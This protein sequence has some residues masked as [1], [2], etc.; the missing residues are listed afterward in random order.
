M[1][2][3]DFKTNEQAEYVDDERQQQSQRRAQRTQQRNPPQQN[4][5][6]KCGLDAFTR[7]GIDGSGGGG[8]S[9]SIALL[10]QI[11]ANVNI[12]TKKRKGIRCQ[13]LLRSHFLQDQL[14]SQRIRKQRYRQQQQQYPSK[15]LSF[16]GARNQSLIGLI[17]MLLI[18]GGVQVSN[19]NMCC[20][21]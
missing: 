7:A 6:R 4:Q 15:I 21:K 12:S 10:P 11:E 9:S 17:C 13:K 19:I 3:S 2:A 16:I 14:H 20:I 18:G 8:S 1:L 5:H